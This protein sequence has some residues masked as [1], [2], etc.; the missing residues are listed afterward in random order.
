MKATRQLDYQ[1]VMM[2]T[3]MPT[4]L[5]HQSKVL[6]RLEKFPGGAVLDGVL[7]SIVNVDLTNVR[8]DM[9]QT[10]LGQLFGGLADTWR[11]LNG[12]KPA[13]SNADVLGASLPRPDRM[14]TSIE[15]KKLALILEVEALEKRLRDASRAREAS[16][17][18]KNALERTRLA[19]EIR[20]LDDEVDELRKKLAV[21]TLQ[22]E[23]ELIYACLE[24]EAVQIS[25]DAKTDEEESLLIAEFG[26]L[27][28][29]LAKLRVSVDRNEAI[30]IDDDELAQLAID[31]PDFKN[32]LGI[33][34][35]AV[36][37]VGQR[38]QMAMQ[39]GTMKLKEGISFYWRGLRLLAGDL[40]YA[41][42]VFVAAVGGTTLKPREVITLRRTAR[43]I[44]TL[45]PFTII[46]IAPLSPIGHVLV[47]S[48]LQRYFPGFFPSSFTN[49]RQDVMQRYEALR[50]Q[51]ALAATE[52]E[53]DKAK[54]MAEMAAMEAFEA[55]EEDEEL[56]KKGAKGGVDV[57][58][59]AARAELIRA[60]RGRGRL[61]LLPERLPGLS[62]GS[63]VAAQSPP[64]SRGFGE[65]KEAAVGSQEG[66]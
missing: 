19:N 47:F 20:V 56:Q 55:S 38:A 24:D 2:S 36:I 16:L 23:M 63:G 42:R 64:N 31:I 12:L 54:E 18:R 60:R 41:G 39:E 7:E 32:R 62:K 5:L 22:L 17:R 8:F 21:R 4:S 27:D 6:R 30:L 43:D 66:L 29:D 52:S 14:W 40:V 1:R 59:K 3:P 51:I 53:R 13:S 9:V 10:K 58:R 35:Q 65:R 25:D 44:L 61:L 28:A 34:Q 11:R 15:E 57:D 37:P 50:E 46:L 45:I 49:K 33:Q 48:F 26:M